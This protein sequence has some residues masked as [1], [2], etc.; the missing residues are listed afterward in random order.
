MAGEGFKSRRGL[1][2]KPFSAERGRGRRGRREGRGEGLRFRERE[3]AKTD[4][5]EEL[6]KSCSHKGRL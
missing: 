1:D 6:R 2:D 4:A 5:K 3:A